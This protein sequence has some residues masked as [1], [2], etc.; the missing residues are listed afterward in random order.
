[1]PPNSPKDA[2]LGATVTLEGTAIALSAGYPLAT[3]ISATLTDISGFVAVTVSPATTPLHRFQAER[4]DRVSGSLCRTGHLAR[5]LHGDRHL[6]GQHRPLLTG[7]SGN[8]VK[9]AWARMG[10]CRFCFPLPA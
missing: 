8:L 7:Q 2:A 3:S 10:P 1:M 6:N 5:D 4:P 9:T